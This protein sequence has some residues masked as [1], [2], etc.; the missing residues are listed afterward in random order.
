MRGHRQGVR[1]LVPKTTKAVQ[2][3]HA[4][5]ERFYPPYDPVV[6]LPGLSN[7]HPVQPS[8]PAGGQ[9]YRVLK[10][11][12]IAVAALPSSSPETSCIPSCRRIHSGVPSPASDN[13]FCNYLQRRHRTQQCLSF[14]SLYLNSSSI[15]TCN[16]AITYSSFRPSGAIGWP[17]F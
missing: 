13:F 10:P 4:M 3:T 12:A 2:Y 16:P 5:S 9:E 14:I 17:A 11:V 15:N 8:Y 6:E 7:L 1:F